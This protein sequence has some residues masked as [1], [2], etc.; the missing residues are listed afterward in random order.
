MLVLFRLITK[1]EIEGISEKAENYTGVAHADTMVGLYWVLDQLGDP[2]DFEIKECDGHAMALSFQTTYEDVSS[3][4]EDGKHFSLKPVHF[5]VS[6]P[7]VEPDE[8]TNK[9]LTEETG[10][11]KVNWEEYK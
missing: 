9:L 8:R 2:N 5:Q 3:D 11:H 10:W 7:F 6:Q 4:T 1:D